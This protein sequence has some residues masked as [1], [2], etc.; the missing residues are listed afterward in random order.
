MC[1]AMLLLKG[2]RECITRSAICK[3]NIVW[4]KEEEALG[5]LQ[6]ASG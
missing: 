2:Q 3:A 6:A 4:Q 5:M 1:K